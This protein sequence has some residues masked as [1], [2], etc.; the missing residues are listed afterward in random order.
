MTGSQQSLFLHDDDESFRPAPSELD[1]LEFV[2]GDTEFDAAALFGGPPRF[3]STSEGLASPSHASPRKHTS[4]KG[5]VEPCSRAPTSRE[6]TETRKRKV[7]GRS[8]TEGGDRT[9]IEAENASGQ[10]SS[11]EDSLPSPQSL[12]LS[13]ANFARRKD[14]STEAN[15]DY[16][17][18]APESLTK[19]TPA[20]KRRK[21]VGA[22]ETDPSTITK[23]SGTFD[24][25]PVKGLVADYRPEAKASWS[26]S[27]H[28]DSEVQQDEVRSQT[29]GTVPMD[30]GKEARYLGTN[31]SSGLEARLDLS[32][33]IAGLPK[34]KNPRPQSSILY[35]VLVSRRPRKRWENRT[36]LSL[37]DANVQS[38]FTAITGTADAAACSSIDVTLKTSEEEW[39]FCLS[40]MDE[41]H[42]EDMKQFILHRAKSS[43][44]GVNNAFRVVEMYMIAREGT[45]A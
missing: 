22:P 17:A 33:R 31:T 14:I 24:K 5:G 3:D 40:R 30:S 6:T 27:Q 44:H 25:T 42:F 34:A 2:R 19:A 29:I 12:L 38:F 21:V 7:Q 20:T 23:Y 41:D 35:W 8:D 13:S 45:K 4:R 16:N 9:L 26:E 39:T 37:R 43:P 18:R 11:D 32:S 15:V 36:N 10:V 1:P 28:S